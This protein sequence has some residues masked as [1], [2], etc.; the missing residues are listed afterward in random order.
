M[1]YGKYI[2]FE[3]EDFVLDPDFVE[4]V[5][6]PVLESDKFW[7]GFLQEHPG[8]RKAVKE[9]VLIVRSIRAIEPEVSG[10]QLN[11]IYSRVVN[12]PLS[13]RRTVFTVL[14]V[15]AVVL[16]L[17]S[18][19]GMLY[20]LTAERQQFPAGL[21]TGE[22]IEKGKVILPDGTVRE[23][24]TEQTTINQTVTGRLTINSDTIETSQGG[25]VAAKAGM[26][27]VHIPYGKRS[28]LTLADGTKIWMNSGSQL[29]YPASFDEQTREVYLSGEA[30]FEV[31]HDP[32]KPFFVVT[33]DIRI[34][35][36]GTRFNVTSYS[37]DNT[38]QAVLVEGKVSA[39]KN[40]MFAKTMELM[41]GERIVYDKALQSVARDKVEVS[42]YASWIDGYLIF[43]RE[44]VKEIFTRLERYY[45]Q[46]II[47][48]SGLSQITFSG[49]LDLSDS[50]GKV[51]ENISF[52]APFTVNYDNG[53]YHIN[54]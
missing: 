33:Q 32:A 20:Y 21:A 23:F 9:A 37:D 11:R 2:D 12:K 25:M 6:H 34:R 14:K 35:V 17:V 48:D 19:G 8:K 38:T 42:L 3:S 7:N 4:W 43:D 44:P 5:Q 10:E 36:L 52:S 40:R 16:F 27:Q 49:K 50:I 47:M 54:P 22:V 24:D 41:P 18:A 13:V 39:G 28:L 29:S 45:N 53:V 26:S 30:F 46:S 1:S 51:F 31:A 15:A